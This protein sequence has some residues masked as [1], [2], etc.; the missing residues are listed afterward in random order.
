MSDPI[1]NARAKLKATQDF[2]QW[3]HDLEH[4]PDIGWNEPTDV[5]IKPDTIGDYLKSAYKLL[6]AVNYD[7]RA[8]ALYIWSSTKFCPSFEEE[9]GLSDIKFVS[10][11]PENRPALC[12]PVQLHRDAVDK[13]HIRLNFG[14]EWI[15]FCSFLDTLVLAAPLDP[16]KMT[17]LWN[18]SGTPFRIL[19]LPRELRDQIWYHAVF[20]KEPPIAHPFHYSRR[21]TKVAGVRCYQASFH[22]VALL[23]P[24]M[25]PQIR[26]EATKVLYTKATFYFMSTRTFSNF[27]FT[28]RPKTWNLI[29]KLELDFGYEGWLHILGAHLSTAVRFNS[30]QSL[31]GLKSLKLRDLN[32]RFR[33]PLNLECSKSKL[34]YGKEG[35]HTKV[36]Q[37]ILE[38]LVAVL[39]HVE[40]KNL[41]FE[42]YIK[43][44]QKARFFDRLKKYKDSLETIDVKPE[45]LVQENDEHEGVLL[46]HPK[47]KTI[48][49]RP[50]CQEEPG[51]PCSRVFDPEEIYPE[52]EL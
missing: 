1:S 34:W 20:Q 12:L 16:A 10:F 22:N 45:D 6:K 39:A 52:M 48:M 23:S 14:G 38:L 8:L 33:E 44:Q 41:R 28:L 9:Y 7:Y 49:V 15:T 11:A 27:F 50:D 31:E 32:I 35:C 4:C 24:K 29:C 2:Y 30:C 37:W 21:G 3:C 51:I 46:D 43:T 25:P 17:H 42:G 26:K 19:D 36:V 5:K 40:I 13:I 47:A 18:K